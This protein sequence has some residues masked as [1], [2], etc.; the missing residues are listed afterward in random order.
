MSS[1][2]RNAH[3]GLQSPQP[4]PGS[5]AL[6]HQEHRPSGYCY[7]HK[8]LQMFQGWDLCGARNACWIDCL[9]AWVSLAAEE[10]GE[11][12]DG[13][14]WLKQVLCRDDMWAPTNRTTLFP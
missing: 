3:S 9:F 10:A 11:D 5:A 1:S 14:R 8:Y 4:P 12:P 13:L 6:L 7:L 2:I